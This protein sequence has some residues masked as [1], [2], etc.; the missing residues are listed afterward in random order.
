[1][2]LAKKCV[3]ILILCATKNR[4]AR[5]F[6]SRVRTIF[7]IVKDEI[8]T[9]D[10]RAMHVSLY[11]AHRHCESF[12][13]TPKT[14]NTKLHH[15]VQDLMKMLCYPLDLHKNKSNHG[16]LP[17][18]TIAETFATGH[19]NFAHQTASPFNMNEQFEPP[20]DLF[21]PNTSLSE[22]YEWA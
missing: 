5:S 3:D 21:P 22:S 2:V 20:V 9:L 16:D 7:A 15:I 19:V 18:P 14:S 12:L 1:M 4:I 17:Y 10:D 11:E 6:L 8:E 13:F